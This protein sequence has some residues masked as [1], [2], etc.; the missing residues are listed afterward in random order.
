MDL[1]FTST[2]W[3]YITSIRHSHQQTGQADQKVNKKYQLNAILAG[4]LGQQAIDFR[5]SSHQLWTPHK[6]K[7]PEA[8]DCCYDC[9]HFGTVQS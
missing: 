9:P 3:W 6:G 7:G 8:G 4:C 1:K 2:Q 5:P